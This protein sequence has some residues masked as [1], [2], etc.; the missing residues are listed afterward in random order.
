M[1]ANRRSFFTAMS[2]AA[3][4]AMLPKSKM[5]AQTTSPVIPSGPTGVIVS[6]NGTVV[7]LYSALADAQTYVAQ[8]PNAKAYNVQVWLVTPVGQSSPLTNTPPS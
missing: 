1:Q 7:G 8:Q 4:A 6:L 5:Q 3:M 2:A